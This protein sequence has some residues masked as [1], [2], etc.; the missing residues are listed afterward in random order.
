M[1]V[2]TGHV[3]LEGISQIYVIC[4]CCARAT[5]VLRQAQVKCQIQTSR[6][7]CGSRVN[8]ANVRKQHMK[9]K[10]SPRRY[11]RNAVEQKAVQ[12]LTMSL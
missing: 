4:V 2:V 12:I 11:H 7:E 6:H 10:N 9:S 1:T 5:A 8:V 3:S